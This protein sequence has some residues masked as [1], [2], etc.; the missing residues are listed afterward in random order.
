[1][2][3]GF[4][5][6]KAALDNLA[7]VDAS[8]RIWDSADFSH[9]NLRFPNLERILRYLLEKDL[10]DCR[11]QVSENLAPIRIRRLDGQGAFWE[12]WQT[13]DAEDGEEKN[14]AVRFLFDVDRGV[15]RPVDFR[16]PFLR[17][18]GDNPLRQKIVA[19]LFV[20]WLANQ[21]FLPE[22]RDLVRCIVP[23]A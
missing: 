20:H 8:G 4:E 5:N 14:P 12:V 2:L 17:I 9:L 21:L 13:R 7:L 16:D 10:K 15:L 19:S 11:V 22:E 18:E 1:M 23:L 3:P 6:E